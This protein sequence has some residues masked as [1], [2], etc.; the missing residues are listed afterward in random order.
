MKDNLVFYHHYADA[1]EHWK[2]KLLRSLLGWS[3]EGRFWAL[4]N[5]IAKSSNCLLDINK[6]HIRA[7]II[8]DLNMDEK[9]FSE[10][11]EILKNECELIVDLDGKITTDIIR[12]NLQ[13]V[14]KDREAARQRKL[15]SKN[16]NFNLFG[17]E[18]K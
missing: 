8:S 11:I 5:M 13:Q 3:A 15:K 7:C 12:E 17:I 6:K 14:K 18:Q 16:K 9:T 2:F 10:F 4:N 1:H